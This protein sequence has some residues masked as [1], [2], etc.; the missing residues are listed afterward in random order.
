M[1]IGPRHLLVM[2]AGA[3]ARPL[4]AGGA[5]K[6]RSE[7]AAL[8][9]L[10]DLIACVIVALIHSPGF[11]RGFGVSLP[12]VF[13]RDLRRRRG[14]G[15]DGRSPLTGSHTSPENCNRNPS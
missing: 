15:Q 13:G 10:A 9:T 6:L 4:I 3:I 12:V 14:R 11:T 2:Y 1:V 8:P 7:Q 5:L